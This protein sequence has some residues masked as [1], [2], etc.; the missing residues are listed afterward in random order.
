MPFLYNKYKLIK[1]LFFDTK[2]IKNI[3]IQ[4]TADVAWMVK[5]FC[6]FVKGVAVKLQL[7]LSGCQLTMEY[8]RQL[9]LLLVL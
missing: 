7:C 4:T 5:Y 9:C 3:T 8:K 1:D 6:L 2:G